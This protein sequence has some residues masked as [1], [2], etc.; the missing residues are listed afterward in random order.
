MPTII[1]MIASGLFSF[2]NR[3]IVTG[4]LGKLVFLVILTWVISVLLGG[5]VALIQQFL[6]LPSLA[7]LLGSFGSTGSMMFYMFTVF[8]QPG[9]SVAIASRVVVFIIRRLPV[10]G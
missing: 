7:G 2:F 10:V 9:L 3:T 1:A 6:N 8:V 5:I 4:L